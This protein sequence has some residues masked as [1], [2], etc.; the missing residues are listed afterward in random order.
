[1][2]NQHTVESALFKSSI[3]RFSEWLDAVGMHSNRRERGQGTEETGDRWDR[4]GAG[5]RDPQRNRRLLKTF[6]GKQAQNRPYRNWNYMT[7][8]AY[9]F[10]ATVACGY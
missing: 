9:Y 3:Y 10:I 7:T 2:L 4:W 6:Q 8:A 1:M 5:S